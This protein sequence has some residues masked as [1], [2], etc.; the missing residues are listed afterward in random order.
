MRNASRSTFPARGYEGAVRANPL[1]P[2][3]SRALLAAAKA[4]AFL[5]N[6]DYLLPDDLQAVF[7]AVAE[8][9]LRSGPSR[10]GSQ[11]S[12]SHKL[13]ALVDPVL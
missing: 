13:L 2:R 3:A 5:A 4:W 9:R 7:S 6:R 12:L 10:P 11:Q 1:S 8:H